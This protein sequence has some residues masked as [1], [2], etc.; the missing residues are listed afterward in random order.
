M[1]THR[2]NK[3]SNN[4]KKRSGFRLNS[5]WHLAL[6]KHSSDVCLNGPGVHLSNLSNYLLNITGSSIKCLTPLNE[7]LIAGPEKVSGNIMKSLMLI[8]T[9]SNI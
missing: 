1:C 9:K 8:Y 7:P 6:V 3:L 2:Q 5:I 4:N